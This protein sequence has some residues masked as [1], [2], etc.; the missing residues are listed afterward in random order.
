MQRNRDDIR[1]IDM[2]DEGE[3]RLRV[4]RILL[5]EPARIVVEF[6]SG[7]MPLL[8]FSFG[9]VDIPGG[10]DRKKGKIGLRSTM[11]GQRNV[12]NRVERL[13]H[14]SLPVRISAD[15]DCLCLGM[16]LREPL[17]GSTSV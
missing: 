7:S 4:R 9:E 13:K 5:D 8:V 10:I 15:G 6:A 17:F 11:M 1:E 3:I 12:Q 2:A 16:L 14:F